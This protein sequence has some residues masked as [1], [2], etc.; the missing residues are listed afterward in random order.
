LGKDIADNKGIKD[1]YRNY[2][3]IASGISSNFKTSSTGKTRK[4]VDEILRRADDSDVRRIITD[5]R[6]KNWPLTCPTKD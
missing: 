1:F 3:N 6:P 5:A 4:M 2:K